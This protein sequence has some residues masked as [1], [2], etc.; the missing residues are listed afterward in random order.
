MGNFAASLQIAKLILYSRTGETREV[1]FRLGGMN[2]LTGASK[3]GKSAIIDIVDYV[4]GRGD[5]NVADGVI[6]KYVGWYAILFQLGDGQIFIASR[7]PEIGERTSGDV[8]LS[9]ASH[10]ETPPASELIKNI[11]VSAL[12]SF[13]G[14]AIGIS[15][16]EHRPPTPTRDPLEANFRHALLFCLQDQNDIDS[17]QRLFHR[18]GEDY[19]GQAIRD[20]LPYF[21]GAIDEDRL[22]KQSQLDEAKRQLRR[23]E[24][25]MRDSEAL[26]SS[27]Y[28]RAQALLDEAKQV[29][30]IDERTVAVDY[31]GV[32]SLLQRIARDTQVRDSAVMGD[33]EDLLSSLRAERQGFRSELERLNSE[34]RSTRTFTTETSGYER[35]AKE[36]RARL[37]AVGL[38][39]SG[40][41]DPNHCPLCESHLAEATPLVAQIERS[42]YE[43]SEQLDAVQAENPRLQVRL[44]NLLREEALLQERLRENQHRIANRMQENEILRVQQETFI[45]QARAAGKISQYVETATSADSGSALRINIEAARVRVAILEKELDPDAIREKLNAFLNIIG[46]YMTTYS[47]QLEL[48]HRGSQLRLDIRNLTVMADTL[49]G[50]VPLFRMGSGENWVGYHVLAHLALHKWFRQKGRPVPAVLIFDQPSQAHYPPE[51]DANGSIDGLSDEDQTA[52]LQLFKVLSDAAKELAPGLQIIVLD[53][54]DLKRD[55]FQDAIVERWRKG[56]ALVPIH[57]IK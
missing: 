2:I 10:I 42:L 35:E 9:R 38:I 15:E 12:E 25:Q 19:V 6:R 53:H 32:F 44:A 20:T 24:R 43:L 26:D 13:L 45:L 55:W 14:A 57:W 7:N 41:H 36:Q 34:I 54:A 49:D 1:S 33:G 31:Q 4:T 37:S 27:T 17:K 39:R 50:P 16:N 48:E 22:L 51:R 28:P 29:G 47:E 23:L 40:K 5:C 8:Y 46:H 56:T 3:T 30:L 52:V 11:T 21:L 18:Q